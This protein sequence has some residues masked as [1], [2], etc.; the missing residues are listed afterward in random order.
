LTVI[1]S[2]H[3]RDGDDVVKDNEGQA[4]VLLQQLEEKKREVDE[5]LVLQFDHFL[6]NFV[7]DSVLLNSHAGRVLAILGLQARF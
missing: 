7:T 4:G 5:G 2:T 3:L 1:H 6:N